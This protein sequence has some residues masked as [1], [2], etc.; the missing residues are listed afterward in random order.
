MV[1]NNII[2][3][4]SSINSFLFSSAISLPRIENK[5]KQPNIIVFLLKNNAHFSTDSFCR[6]QHNVLNTSNSL[7]HASLKNLYGDGLHFVFGIGQSKSGVAHLVEHEIRRRLNEISS[8]G[9][10]NKKIIW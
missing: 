6:Q 10:A 5:K 1:S 9:N 2:A 3:L 8:Q 4:D 7:C